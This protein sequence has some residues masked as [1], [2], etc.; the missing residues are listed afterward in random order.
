MWVGLASACPRK[1]WSGAQRRAV[2]RQARGEGVPQVVEA[3]DPHTRVAAG[4]LELLGDLRGVERAPELGVRED[5]G[6]FA[7][8][9][10]GGV[11]AQAARA[12]AAADGLAPAQPEE[13]RAVDPAGELV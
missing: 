7:S 4:P 3:H 5:E 13:R 11:E 6:R 1:S 8:S 2:G 9:G 10:I 12:L